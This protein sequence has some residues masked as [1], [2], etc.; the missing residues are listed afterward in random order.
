[1]GDS[2]E[3]DEA[4]T[5]ESV[6]DVLGGLGSLFNFVSVVVGE[7]SSILD[8]ISMVVNGMSGLGSTVLDGVSSRVGSVGDGMSCVG[9]LA[10]PAQFFE[11]EVLKVLKGIP[12]FVGGNSSSTDLMSVV[13]E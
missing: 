4:F 5:V 8:L 2:D 9:K 10:S 11:V 3:E 7:L 6:I 12:G 1:M 13:V